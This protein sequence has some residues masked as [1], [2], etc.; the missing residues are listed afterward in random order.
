MRAP[1]GI[2]FDLDGTL[3]DSRRDI[4][5]AC[6]HA[7]VAT[8]RAPLDLD[9]IAGFVG[10]GVRT[11]VARASGLPEDAP[12]LELLVQALVTYYAAHPVV[13]TT[14]MP[15]A[16]TALDSFRDLPIALVTNKARPVTL[17]VLEA[18]GVGARFTFV[19]A[20]GDGPL[21]PAAAPVEAAARGLG[22]SVDAMWVVGDGPQDILAARAAGAPAIAL[23]GGFTSEARLRDAGPEAVLA[24]L[25]ELDELRRH[26]SPG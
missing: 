23:L 2:A 12:D 16:L 8:G 22:V 25:G 7:L 19:Y 18:L 1:R 3:V 11:L 15:G 13:H 21:K 20:G 17:A 9:V 26:A 14:W 10:D 5:A 6:N 24:S 4:A